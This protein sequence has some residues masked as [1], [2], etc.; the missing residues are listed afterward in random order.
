LAQRREAGA[1]LQTG[2]KG[3]VLVIPVQ[4]ERGRYGIVM[5][6][7]VAEISWIYRLTSMGFN[8][9]RLELLAAKS[10]KYDMSSTVLQHGRA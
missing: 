4:L 9:N 10:W 3:D 2:N 1:G 5:V 8:P 7:T 6:D